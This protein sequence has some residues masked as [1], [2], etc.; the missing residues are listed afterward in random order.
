M[1]AAQREESDPQSVGQSASVS[2]FIP[3]MSTIILI[4]HSHTVVDICS[5]DGLDVAFVDP[6]LQDIQRVLKEH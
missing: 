5:G 6:T 1:P 3:F 4:R 2:L